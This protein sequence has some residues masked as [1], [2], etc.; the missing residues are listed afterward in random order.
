[1]GGSEYP[2][3]THACAVEHAHSLIHS[4][5]VFLCESNVV[6]KKGGKKGLPVKMSIMTAID[7]Q[8]RPLVDT[9]GNFTKETTVQKIDFE[10]YDFQ[11]PFFSF[12]F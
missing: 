10:T 3:K 9:V 1:M 7:G 2:E 11:I 8:H 12:D 6:T 4:F 5:C